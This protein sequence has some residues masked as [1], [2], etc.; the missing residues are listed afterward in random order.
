M[1]GLVTLFD[2]TRKVSHELE[3][4]GQFLIK[5]EAR[6]ALGANVSTVRRFGAMQ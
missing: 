5:E 1:T 4:V 6:M 2:L 3:F